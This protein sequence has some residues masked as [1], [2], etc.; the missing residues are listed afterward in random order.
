LKALIFAAGLGTRLRPYTNSKPKALVEVAG[1][2]MLEHI[3]LKLKGFGI[4]EF[5]VNIHHF[6]DQ[7]IQFLDM[8][9]N[10]D[11]DIIISDERKQ[12]LDTGGGLKKALSYLS[13]N[14]D[15]LVHNVDILT[16]YNLK[17]LIVSHQKKKNMASLLVQKR[18]TSRYLL[19]S[20][21]SLELRGW[22]N[23]KTNEQ[24]PEYLDVSKYISLA[25][26]GIH[27]V[28]SQISNLLPQES[29]FPI[30]PEYLKLSLDHQIRGLL[31]ENAYWLDLGKPA[32]LKIA[33]KL[34][35][36]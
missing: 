20:P 15:L 32:Q 11:C 13:A 24:L 29:T 31:L 27:I 22:I 8:K 3:I 34:L 25:F 14:E 12:L 5:I 23:T 7:I 2:S 30:I 36:T 9:N 4:H 28:N 17:N 26:S 35:N 19:F 16:N 10:F 1:K 18:E 6:G 33:E 21:D